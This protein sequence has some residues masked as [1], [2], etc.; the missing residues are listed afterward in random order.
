VDLSGIGTLIIEQGDSESLEIS[1]EENLMPYLESRVVAGRLELGTR[2]MVNIQPTKE[3]VYRLKVIDLSAINTS[4]LGNVKIGSIE[5]GRLN[6]DI[7][8]SGNVEI[9]NVQ[10]K[11]IRL[12]IS[13]LGDIT[14]A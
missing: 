14:L 13:G 3:I 9:D 2:Q 12:D 1:A 8:G 11:N 5:T 6:I 4:G 7:S 10:V